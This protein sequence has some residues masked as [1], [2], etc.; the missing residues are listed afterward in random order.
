MLEQQQVQPRAEHADDEQASRARRIIPA[1]CGSVEFAVLDRWESSSNQVLTV[2]GLLRDFSVS[3]GR[4]IIRSTSRLIDATILRLLVC[5]AGWASPAAA[6]PSPFSY[7]DVRLPGPAVELTV[8]A[9]ILDMAHDLD[10]RREGLLD[11]AALG[12]HA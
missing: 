9:H 6:H 12:R 4:P 1:V 3:A 7:L 2:G 5:W 11:P 10:I 8:V